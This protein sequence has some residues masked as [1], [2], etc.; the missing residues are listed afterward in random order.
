MM[1]TMVKDYVNDNGGN[2]GYGYNHG[3]C[4]DEGIIMVLLMMTM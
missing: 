3:L 4:S 1:A 2:S